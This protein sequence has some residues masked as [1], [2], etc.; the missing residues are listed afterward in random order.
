MTRDG[1][2]TGPV[3][4]EGLAGFRT[5]GNEPLAR[6]TIGKPDDFARGVGD[7]VCVIPDDIADENHFRQAA[8]LALGRV[9]HSPQVALVQ[10]L[11]SC[12]Q[13]G[14]ARGRIGFGRQ[15]GQ[16]VLDLDNR[17]HSVAGLPEKFQTNRPHMRRH[18]VQHPAR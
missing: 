18:A 12:Q 15:G 11:E 13:H 5:D 1:G 16:I 9:T 3:K 6:T 17:R 4:P 7:C 10:M 14:G 8:A 2:G